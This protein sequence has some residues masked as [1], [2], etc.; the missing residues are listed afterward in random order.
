M[1][2]DYSDDL[3][4]LVGKGPMARSEITLK[5]WDYVKAYKLQAEDDKRQID[6]DETLSKVIGKSRISVFNMTADVNKH[7]E[8]G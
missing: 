1:K 6:T 7:I 8:R 4:A 3:V 5:L 2:V